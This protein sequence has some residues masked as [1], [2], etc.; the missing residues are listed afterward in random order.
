MNVIPRY[1]RRLRPTLDIHSICESHSHAFSKSADSCVW[2]LREIDLTISYL[3][4]PA[5]VGRRRVGSSLFVN[6]SRRASKAGA[7]LARLE[8]AGGRARQPALWRGAR[9]YT[10]RVDNR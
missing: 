9:P 2:D 5:S 8:T 10:R 1:S 3:K 7:R 4:S 6:P